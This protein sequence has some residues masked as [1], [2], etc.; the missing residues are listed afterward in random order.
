MTSQALYDLIYLDFNKA[1]SVYSQIKGGLISQ[2]QSVIENTD[3]LS[4]SAGIDIKILKAQIGG[5]SQEKT[6]LLETRTI[7][8][9]L[10]VKL[11]SELKDAGFLLDLNEAGL[12]QNDSF[13]LTRN[14]LKQFDYV[15]VEGWATIE[16]YERLKRLAEKFNDISRFIKE[17]QIDNSEVGD[18]VKKL[19]QQLEDFRKKVSKETN[20]NK[21]AQEQAKLKKLQS[22]FDR[23][24]QADKIPDYL[25]NGIQLFINTFLPGRINFRVYPFEEHP[26][27]QLFAN[28]KRECFID[29]DIE[30]LIFSYGSTPNIKLT[31][32]GLITSIPEKEGNK[33]DPLKEFDK[34]VEQTPEE[35]FERAFR[36]V[37]KGFEGLESFVRYSRYPNVTISPIA[38]YRNI[39]RNM[40]D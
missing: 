17:C 28:L 18:E 16:D 24:T 8:H 37:F 30:N 33:F 34:D 13:D 38:V 32:L 35:I 6:S 39:K 23:I 21:K 20:P 9:D 2:I 10:L 14:Q 27:F 26:S 4:P 15:K 36:G 12:K 25:I 11:E 5:I 1:S 29:T 31:I 7:H 22:D 19:H 40:I 3:N